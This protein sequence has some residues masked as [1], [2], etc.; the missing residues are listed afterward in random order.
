VQVKRHSTVCFWL[1]AAAMKVRP[2]NE[3]DD[4]GGDGDGG[5]E[6]QCLGRIGCLRRCSS[7]WLAEVREFSSRGG[8]FDPNSNIRSVWDSIVLVLALYHLFE[9]PYVVAFDVQLSPGLKALDV[10]LDVVFMVD[11]AVV[12]RTAIYN[13][14][15]ELV[16]NKRALFNAY[17][18][19]TFAVLCLRGMLRRR[20]RG[21]ADLR[22]VA[23]AGGRQRCCGVLQG[24]LSS[25][26][27]RPYHCT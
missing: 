6:R 9:T 26:C 24:T 4:D 23:V 18:R 8:V 16:T 14:W 3:P 15:R 25:M 5:T 1:G 21:R 19:G 20:R 17:L 13:K 7:V 27:S 11:V 12:A 2:S 10:L 22:R